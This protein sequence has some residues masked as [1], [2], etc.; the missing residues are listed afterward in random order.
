MQ[1]E[2]DKLIEN[3]VDFDGKAFDILRLAH[4]SANAQITGAKKRLEAGQ[5]AVVDPEVILFANFQ[6]S[7]K[8]PD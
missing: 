7:D 8:Y 1:E 5:Y 2:S 3:L 4:A 6:V